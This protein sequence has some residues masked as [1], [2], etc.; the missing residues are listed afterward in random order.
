M[1]GRVVVLGV[2]NADTTYRV[3]RVPR[4]GETVLG[5]GFALG[6]GGKGSNQAVAAALSG[7]ETHMITRLGR[8]A[9]AEL[10]REVW[11]EAGV[12][13]AA[14]TSD[15]RPTGAACIL[16]EEE[17]VQNR[18][19]VAPGAASAMDEGDAEANERLIAGA[20]VFLTQLEQP[21]TSALRGLEIARAHGGRTILNP[22]PAVDLPDEMLA[23]CDIVTPNESETEAM[24][25][26]RVTTLDEARSGARALRERGAGAALITLGATGALWSDGETEEHIA[27]MPSGPVIDTTGA[28]DALNGGF[29]AGL[30]QGMD[31]VEAARFGSAVAGIAITRQGAAAAMPTLEETRAHLAAQGG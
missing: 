19:V 11:Q 8:D 22:A 31:P 1:T 2:F 29:A 14:R 24:T 28:G 25:G 20:Q 26:Q 13:D 5:T 6:P 16:V 30:A 23:L 17:T 12:R 10:A 21:V 4:A 9:F 7:A 15:D 27:P 3:A 18:I